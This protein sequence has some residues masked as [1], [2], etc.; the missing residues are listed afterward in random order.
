ML[1]GKLLSSEARR[2]LVAFARE[3]SLQRNPESLLTGMAGSLLG[4]KAELLPRHAAY[5]CEV[6]TEG[7]CST[8]INS[9]KQ[10]LAQGL[11]VPLAP[12]S[13]LEPPFRR[14]ELWAWLHDNA[15]WLTKEGFSLGDWYASPWYRKLGAYLKQN[16]WVIL[17]AISATI[18]LVLILLNFLGMFNK[19]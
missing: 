17:A 12:V 9:I 6:C 4:E 3:I 11:I 8:A 19:Y 7:E 15:F 5:R 18:T 10:L 16:V 1:I 14:D 13:R 2:L